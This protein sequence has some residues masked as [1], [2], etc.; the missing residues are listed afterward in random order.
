M[1]E[2]LIVRRGGG[3]SNEVGEITWA[4]RT[5]ATTAG[6]TIYSAHDN[7]NAVYGGGQMNKHRP[8]SDNLWYEGTVGVYGTTAVSTTAY[9][10]TS[11]EYG[12]ATVSER[13]A[14]VEIS[15]NKITIPN[16]LAF[17]EA[18]INLQLVICHV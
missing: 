13:T 9:S 17:E 4:E 15:G 12:N 1:G 5:T 6:K 3:K 8:T 11:S 10:T 18:Q 16:R 7:P 2:G 14:T